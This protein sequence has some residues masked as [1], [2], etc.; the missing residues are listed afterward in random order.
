MTSE[1]CP[2]CLLQPRDWFCD[3]CDLAYCD[4]CWLQR[5]PHIRKEET[6]VKHPYTT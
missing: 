6:H 5:G 1:L 2:E 4:G 3:G